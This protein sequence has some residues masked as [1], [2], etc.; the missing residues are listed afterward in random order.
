MAKGYVPISMKNDFARIYAE[1]IT[2]AAQQFREREWNT[3]FSEE[4]AA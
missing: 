1:G 2:P 4:E 3:A